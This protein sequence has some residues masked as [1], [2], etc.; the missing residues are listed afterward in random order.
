MYCIHVVSPCNKNCSQFSSFFFRL[1]IV[2]VCIICCFLSDAKVG[3]RKQ[4]FHL[5]QLLLVCGIKGS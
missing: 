2:A 4:K 5:I 3:V 1:S